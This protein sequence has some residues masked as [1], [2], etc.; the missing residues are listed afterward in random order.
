MEKAR[1]IALTDVNPSRFSWTEK[2][3]I[4][5][6]VRMLLYANE[7]DI[8]GIVLC[9]SCFLKHG[10][11]RGAEKVVQNLLKAYAAAKLNLDLHAAGYPEADT[12]R[13]HVFR[14]I[15]AFGQA[16]GC[17]F[18]EE[19]YND[20][21]GV[22]CII[23]A[24][25]A[26]DPR[27]VWVGLWGG[28]NTLAQAIWQVSC[29]RSEAELKRFLHRLRI[30]SISDQD[31]S[32]AWIRKNWGRDL[33]YRV[34]PSLGTMKGTKQYC[35]A[36]WPGISGDNFQHGSEDG[37]QGGGFTGA[38]K[39]VF[40][41]AWLDEHIRTVG[42]LGACYPKT[43]Y[44]AEGDTPAFLSLLPNG[45][46]KPEHPELGGWAGRYLQTNSP[47]QAPIW[48]GAADT[49]TGTDGRQHTNPQAGLWRWRTDFQNEFAAR[50]QWTVQADYADCVHPPV[51][52]FQG[53]I[54]DGQY[55]GRSVEL[56]AS[57]SCNP[58]GGP[59]IFRWFW[60]TE[61]CSQTP[62]PML[63]ETAPGC[64]TVTMQAEGRF[65]LILAVRGEKAPYITRYARLELTFQKE[66][67]DFDTAIVKM[68]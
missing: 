57:P 28:A 12:L 47:E 31:N 7:I 46:N 42:S 27:P 61:L 44:L 56:D 26:P 4:Q 13:A 51:I 68:I 2:D 55:T 53:I 34:E 54:P 35:R 10:G 67:R 52:R 49:V 43:V 64:V 3:D 65:H 58:D 5:S 48:S 19:R 63:I 50:M 45:L 38:D 8:E 9:S 33:F 62:L 24:V 17:G 23:R 16:P 37:M 39:E 21:S 30:L 20:N 66:N 22:Q 15:P 60:Y 32:A 14:G 11:G 59:L 1:Y 41:E 25:D 40:S 18:A 29:T 6:L 36:V